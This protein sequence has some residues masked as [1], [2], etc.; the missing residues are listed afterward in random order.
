MRVLSWATAADD[1]SDQQLRRYIEMA[2]EVE[3]TLNTSSLVCFR[4][5]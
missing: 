5:A 3:E 4:R 1:G 2:E